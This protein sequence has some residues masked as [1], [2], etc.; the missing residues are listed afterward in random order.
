MTDI[1]IYIYKES[2]SK[3]KKKKEKKRANK[4]QLGQYESIS[5][6]NPTNHHMDEMQ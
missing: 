3:F 4:I 1:Y 5:N 6:P 2:N